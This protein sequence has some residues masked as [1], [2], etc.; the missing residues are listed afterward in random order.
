MFAPGI[1]IHA[2]HPVL[3]LITG[4]FHPKAD[5]QELSDK[6]TAWNLLFLKENEIKTY[7]VIALLQ[8]TPNKR[9]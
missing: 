7:L 6:P 3:S 5:D 4:S 1:I 2:Q 8:D 9:V